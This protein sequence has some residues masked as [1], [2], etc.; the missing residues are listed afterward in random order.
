MNERPGVM[1][2]SNFRTEFSRNPQQELSNM[3]S[4]WDQRPN[5]AALIGLVK[6]HDISAQSV[7]FAGKSLGLKTPDMG[8]IF[9]DL[10]TM[11]PLINQLVDSVATQH[12]GANMV[13]L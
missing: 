9:F 8:E 7:A 5:T 6:S 2:P 1:R 13:F 11:L 12:N 10:K 4:R 3:L